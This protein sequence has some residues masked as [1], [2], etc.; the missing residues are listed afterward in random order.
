M[1]GQDSTSLSGWGRYPSVD[2]F[3]DR[4]E[5]RASLL[6]A[7]QNSGGTNSSGAG[8]GDLLARG[9]GRSYGDAA[10]AACGQTVLM[11]KLNRFMAF[12]SETGLL[13]LE[14]GVTIAEILQTFIPKG[15]FSPVVPGTK[16]VTV[17]GAIAADIHGKN[18]H[19][20]GSFSNFVT[21]FWLLTAAG[22]IIECSRIQNADI[23][24]ATIGGMGLTGIIVE[25]ELTLSPIESSYISYKSIRA[26]N[27]TELMGLFDQHE[28][29]HHYSVAWIDCLAQK[30]SLGRGV[31]LLG[32]HA[33]LT[34]LP[35]QLKNHPLT[36]KP[37]KQVTV[38]F[39][40]PSSLLNRYT[41]STFNS[42][43]YA[44]KTNQEKI[45]DYDS[46]FFPL[47]AIGSWNRM[48]G[49]A[50]FIQYQCVIPPAA[51]KQALTEILNAC[52][53]KGWGSFLAVLKRFGSKT[54]P[55]NTSL[56]FPIAGYT[57]TLDFPV[58]ASLIEFTRK[59][60][61]LVISHG[62][63][64]YLAKDACLTPETF[65]TMYN[66]NFENWRQIKHKIDPDNVFRSA[67]SQRLEI[68]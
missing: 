29:R 68:N 9:K 11:E 24:W 8:S 13:R 60:D 51:S 37:D 5:S 12:D 23:F 40:M 22:E 49:K 17:G 34:D 46:Y 30:N 19:R 56:S 31:L 55:S 26:D 32:D 7:V 61:E 6:Q 18:H 20:D 58:K 57:L 25:A 36:L 43:F 33:K 35:E 42:L 3:I 50:G 14:P 64:V 54:C 10:E 39:D 65:R 44:V 38:P 41:M 52:S 63:R 66:A 28:E 53:Q 21:R 48:Y 1:A 59:L 45:A 2:T 67:L 4:P 16:F 27:L 47:D 62:G 15:W